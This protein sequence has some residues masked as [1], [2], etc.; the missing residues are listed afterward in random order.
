L[1]AIITKA[2]AANPMQR[3]RH[4]A[5]RARAGG[6]FLQDQALHFPMAAMLAAGK[7]HAVSCVSRLK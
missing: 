1:K 6:E 2:P 3:S 4:F 5:D 7:A